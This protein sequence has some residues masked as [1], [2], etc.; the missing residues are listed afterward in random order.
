MR[1]LGKLLLVAVFL[2]GAYLVYQ[3][4]EIK[5]LFRE[6]K[7]NG[8]PLAFLKNLPEINPKPR[9]VK[10]SGARR[11]GTQEPQA[12]G[13]PQPE[14]VD[15]EGE[16]EPTVEYY[17]Q[18]A[19]EE[20]QSVLMRILAAKKLVQ[21]ISLSVTDKSVIVSGAVESEER[22]QEILG[23]IEKGREARSIDDAYLKVRD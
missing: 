1:F 13:V 22:R 10:R 14:N 6:S 21:G 16:A 4:P 15:A 2:A 20:L 8:D 18:V 23:I 19:N 17:N 5:E 3:R 12:Q 11:A 9:P 7:S